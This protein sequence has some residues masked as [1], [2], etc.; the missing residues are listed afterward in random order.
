M[1]I[2]KKFKLMGQT[3]EVSFDDSIYRD[4][5]YEGYASYRKN[6]IVMQSDGHQ[7]PLKPEQIEQTFL[8]E[9]VHHISYHAGSAINHELK[10]GLHQNEDFVDLFAHLLHQAL[11]TMEY[12]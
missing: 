6:K 2:P 12:E 1:K 5:D 4:R 10:Q 11:T 7:V 3:I 8:H 9:L